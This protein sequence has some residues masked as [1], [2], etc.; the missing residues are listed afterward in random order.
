MSQLKRIHAFAVNL[1]FNPHQLVGRL[2]N[3]HPLAEQGH[4]TTILG[5]AHSN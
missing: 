1:A 2:S 4:T 5:H 3:G